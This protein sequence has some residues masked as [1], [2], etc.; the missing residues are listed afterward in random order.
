[1]GEL[2]TVGHEGQGAGELRYAAIQLDRAFGCRLV[3]HD[4]YMTANPLCRLPKTPQIAGFSRFGCGLQSCT[5]PPGLAENSP[6]SPS[7]SPVLWTSRLSSPQ[8]HFRNSLQVKGL[9]V[10]SGER[11]FG[12]NAGPAG[13]EQRGERETQNRSCWRRNVLELRWIV[14][15]FAATSPWR[16]RAEILDHT[17][18]HLDRFFDQSAWRN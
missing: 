1:M 5:S 12:V 16:C 4:Q 18:H 15:R 11:F 17:A 13:C 6:N 8:E 14:G 10:V 7:L 2:A 3:R 9:R